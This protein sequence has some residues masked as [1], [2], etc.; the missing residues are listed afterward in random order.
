MFVFYHSYVVGNVNVCVCI[1]PFI[2][3]GN[4]NVHVYEKCLP[5]LE[6]RIVLYE[7]VEIVFHS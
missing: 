4:V 7:S 1:L 3:G 6:I 5:F 2:G